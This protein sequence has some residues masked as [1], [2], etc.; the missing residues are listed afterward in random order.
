MCTT[1]EKFKLDEVINGSIGKPRHLFVVIKIIDSMST[2]TS[3][4]CKH[5]HTQPKKGPRN[6]RT[7]SPPPKSILNKNTFRKKHL[8]I[9]NI[10]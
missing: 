9:L 7:K 5:T 3:R 1:K 6:T 8:I 10:F 2:L 4:S